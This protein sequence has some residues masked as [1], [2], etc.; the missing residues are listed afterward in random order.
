MAFYKVYII[1]LFSIQDSHSI[2]FFGWDLRVTMVMGLCLTPDILTPKFPFS[3]PNLTHNNHKPH[4][5]LLL[6]LREVNLHQYQ[7]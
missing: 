4:I 3:Y 7:I 1:L 5:L 6:L 2:P